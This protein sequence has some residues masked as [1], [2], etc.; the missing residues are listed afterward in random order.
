MYY[1]GIDLGGTNI[2]AG[3][4]NE[5]YE[6]IAKEKTKTK[7]PRSAKEVIADIAMITKKV[8]EKSGL[9]M[10]DIN[11]IGVGTPGTANKETGI[12][13]YSN[14]LKWDN[15]NLSKMLQ[16][17]LNKK[18]YI[19]NDANAAA[20]GEYIAGAGKGKKSLVAITLGTG[21]GGGVILEDKIL[22]GFSYS[23]AELGH[24]VINFDGESCGCGRKGC[25]EAYASA[26]A[27]IKQTQRAMIND[28]YSRMW[29]IVDGDISKVNGKTAFDGL[30]DNDETAKEVVD[31][32]ITYLGIGVANMINI[33][34]PEV[35]CIGG[36]ICKEGD[37][38]IKPLI[39][40]VNPQTYAIKDE[41]RTKIVVAQLGN[42]AGVIG[43]ALLATEKR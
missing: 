32:Y 40:K 42:D 23:G 31:K 5:N 11:S 9:S 34:Q 30:R 25:L 28:K 36:G 41:N 6:I 12:V 13:E 27:L 2:V 22:T 29:E 33:F 37:T 35:L 21:V 3:V 17:H 8:V 15:V 38:L 1:I 24:S 4:V 14:N 10:N 39:Q 43:A 26:T 16:E 20:F 7:L 18:V 19:E